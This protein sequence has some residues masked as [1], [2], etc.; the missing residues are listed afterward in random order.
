MSLVEQI[1]RDSG[2]A[3]AIVVQDGAGIYI[4]T[5]RATSMTPRAKSPSKAF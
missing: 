1:S 3:K 4:E 5:T 2:V